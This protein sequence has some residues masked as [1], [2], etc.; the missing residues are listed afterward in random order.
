MKA[1]SANHRL[2]PFLSALIV[3][4]LSAPT[5]SALEVHPGN[6]YN[7]LMSEDQSISECDHPNLHGCNYDVDLSENWIRAAIN[8]SA[9]GYDQLGVA[10]FKDFTVAPSAS[11]NENNLT[12]SYL[13]VTIR[14]A[15]H[16]E[17]FG[18]FQRA[19]YEIQF[20]VRDLENNNLIARESISDGQVA[21]TT[22]IGTDLIPFPARDFQT[23]SGEEKIALPL[24]L[25]TGHEYRIVLNIKVD[26]NLS[27]PTKLASSDFYSKVAEDWNSLF[28]FGGVKWSGLSLS[29]GTDPFQAVDSLRELLET[30]THMYLTG[31]GVGHNNIEAI[32]SA[33]IF[34]DSGSVSDDVMESLPEVE[35]DIERVTAR[36]KLYPNYPN[37]FNPSTTISYS[38]SEPTNVSIIIYNSLGQ[39]VKT[40]VDEFKAV[41]EHSVVF[42]AS[43]LASG[44]YYYRLLTDSFVETRKLVLLK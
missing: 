2:F 1:L 23:P 33:A 44:V 19:G 43:E 8:P 18:V 41:G 11:G 42:D 14:Y 16:L 32:T 30:H 5:L 21:G 20:Y 3:F 15:G 27:D 28:D 4:W 22:E 12:G 25:T 31:K 10:I 29:V 24:P 39:T 26:A 38:L 7:N 6:T 37:P 17:G 13:N 40:L 36:S 35:A 9:S 34:M